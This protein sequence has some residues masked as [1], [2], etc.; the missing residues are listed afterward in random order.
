MTPLDPSVQEA[1]LCNR[2]A[3]QSTLIL[4][5]NLSN[6]EI[7]HDVIESEAP[8]LHASC[9]KYLAMLALQSH[10]MNQKQAA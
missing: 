1:A 5:R 7:L 10:P 8:W 4:G 9:S 2:G 6:V 3:L